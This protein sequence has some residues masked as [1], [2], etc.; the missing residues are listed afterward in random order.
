MLLT[1][2]HICYY[3]QSSSILAAIISNLPYEILLT[4][5]MLTCVIYYHIISLLQCLDNLTL[6]IMECL[7]PLF[8]ANSTAFSILSLP[9]YFPLSLSSFLKT[10]PRNQSCNLSILPFKGTFIVF[11]PNYISIAFS[12]FFSFSNDP[13]FTSI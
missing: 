5:C 10:C 7:S 3:E 2:Y 13:G 1:L 11:L 12:L 9:V 4:R 8:L 6:A